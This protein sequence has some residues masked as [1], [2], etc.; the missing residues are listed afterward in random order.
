MKNKT[1]VIQKSKYMCGLLRRGY[2]L[3]EILVVLAIIM[4]LIGMAMVW[5]ASARKRAQVQ[6]TQLKMGNM[7]AI[8]SALKLH[9]PIVPDHRLANFYWVD[10]DLTGTTAPNPATSR[11]MSS[12]E[13]LAFL[14]STIV[15]TNTQWELL[16]ENLRPTPI[17][18]VLPVDEKVL[19]FERAPN[20]DNAIAKAAGIG[21][22]AD[23]SNSSSVGANVA[24]LYTLRPYQLV[25]PAG[26]WRLRTPCDAWRREMVYRYYTDASELN[27]TANTFEDITGDGSFT[28]VIETKASGAVRPAV[29]AYGYPS[30]MSAG[31]DGKWGGFIDGAA[32][33][34]VRDGAAA[35]PRT[36]RD[37]DAR[38]NVYSQE[39]E[40]R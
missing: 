34:F 20:F 12:G 8:A 39:S 21:T 10:R 27:A 38:D 18:G 2:T 6:S 26:G 7:L 40:N 1:N 32:P 36:A 5:G 28:P 37:E 15:D 14:A 31:P 3:V 9:S 11:Q 16:G 19:V 4:A 33:D 24:N 35:D 17:Q 23:L 13:L 29:A 30:F 25:S 22:G